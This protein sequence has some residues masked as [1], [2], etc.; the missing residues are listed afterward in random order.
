LFFHLRNH[1][2]ACGPG[3]FKVYVDRSVPE[4]LCHFLDG[5]SYPNSG[6]AHENVDSFEVFEGG[7]DE[8]LSFK[9]IGNIGL[10]RDRFHSPSLRCV[11][12]RRRCFLA[13]EVIDNNMRTQ[14]RQ[15]FNDRSA[16]PARASCNYCYAAAEC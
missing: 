1:G 15:K 10:K 7:I 16:D 6:I 14:L 3:A 8:S 4:F 2:P 11:Y 12:R 13:P 9:W 5:S